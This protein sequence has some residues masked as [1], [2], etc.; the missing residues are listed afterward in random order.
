M[1]TPTGSDPF[2]ALASEL[3]ALGRRLDGIGAE[4][5]TLRPEE[6]PVQ[7]AQPA[8][9]APPAPPA[10]VP[11][12]VP[13][14]G[15]PVHPPQGFQQPGPIA[16][17]VPGPIP[18]PISGPQ[19]AQAGPWPNPYA[20]NPYAPNPYA[21]SPQAPNPYAQAPR[22]PQPGAPARPAEP[23]PPFWT[24]LSGARLLAWTGGA[25]TLLGV[26]MLMVFAAA[27]G[28]FPPE[29]RIALG[30]VLGVVLVG[31]AMWLH[32]KETARTGALALAGTG[33]ATLYLVVAAAMNVFGY[34][35]PWA[36]VIIALV[37]AG[38]GL[39]IADLW[40]SQLLACGVVVGAVA[41]APALA[42]GWM[43]VALALALQLA[44]LP[45]LL[46]RRWGVLMLIAAA[47]SVLYG[48]PLAVFDGSASP[49]E[50]V[51]AIVVSLIV[52]AVG[53]GTVVPAARRLP[54]G[55]V[56]PVL[57][58]GPLPALFGGIAIDGWLGAA[59]AAGAAL[60]LAGLAAVP[61]LDKQLR[62]TATIAAVVG[63][64]IATAVALDGSTYTIVVLGQAVVGAVTAYVLR[65]RFAMIVAIVLGVIGWVRAL[66]VDL[67]LRLL[68][69]PEL[70]WY[71]H[72][73]ELG[74]GLA[75]AALLLV[76]AW[77]ALVAGG[78]LGWIRPTADSAV[79]WVP[80]GLGGLY[81]ATGVVITA[82]LLV[83]PTRDAFT[84]GHAVVT[85]SWTIAAL[86]L[87]ARGISRTAL[88]VAGLVLVGAAVAKLVF[89]DLG[90]LDGIARVIAFLGA[91]LV[92]L[93]AGTKYARMVAEAERE[94]ADND[95]AA[96]PGPPEQR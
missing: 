62:L 14:S 50:Q 78:R 63:I 70:P 94:P 20:P 71:G 2:A 66:V 80:M 43:L 56:V 75:V 96:V 42:W 48:I 28:W 3:T 1:G 53:L 36:A 16:G 35:D 15:W 11:P 93:A 57:A 73:H 41:L 90:A 33:F 52:L 84:A 9:A 29:A 85:V 23:R 40:R 61:G 24:R 58:A 27:R 68:V 6:R 25:V 64:T 4:L 45:V 51:T 19:P 79:I 21:P 22:P 37:V 91:G 76:L 86:V 81:G 74:A 34:L 59:L 87:L 47:G 49:A 72:Q 39:G 7:P 69:A 82:A 46:R 17:T 10:P 83:A 18:G 8:Q 5:M 60:A 54:V 12:S 38:A 95:A 26:V 13:G 89:F 67:P 77:A 44:A 65:S 55:M 92:L 31:L 88:R 30:G 32:R